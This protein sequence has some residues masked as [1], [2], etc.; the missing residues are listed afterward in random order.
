M[1][2][3]ICCAL[4]NFDLVGT[5]SL[6]GELHII[7]YGSA[8]CLIYGNFCA[9]NITENR[10]AQSWANTWFTMMVEGVLKIMATL[11]V[12]ISLFSD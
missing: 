8:Y 10:R 4:D 12:Y 2:L 11:L 3:N 1:D 7:Y 9:S 6:E 5:L